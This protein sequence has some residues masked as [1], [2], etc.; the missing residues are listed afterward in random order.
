MLVRLFRSNQ[1]GVMVVLALLV[2][3][4]FLGHF[5]ATPADLSGGMPLARALA[6]LFARYPWVYGAAVTL[7][8]VAMALQVTALMNATELTVRRNHLPALL[9]PIAL[10]LVAPP[11]GVGAAF[12]AM[13]FVVWAMH[14]T[15]SMTSGGSALG[16]LFDAGLLL[17]IAAQVYVPFAFLLVVV[18]ASVSVIR[19]FQWREYLVPFIG[20]VVV[21]YLAWGILVLQHST[22]VSPLRTVIGSTIGLVRAPAG[23]GWTLALV[24]APLLLVA[25]L[26]FIEYYGRGV[27]REQN[28]RSAF[29]AFGLTLA[30]LCLLARFITDRF[31]V[32]LVAVPLAMLATFAVVGTRRAWLGEMAIGS[33]LLLA[34]WLQY[35]PA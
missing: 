7:T 9:V 23:F 8:V 12:F 24:L 32:V 30:L 3:G 26:R 11:G 19:P 4:L 25:M 35:A 21:F 15:W 10:A 20:V 17:G 14:R 18:W 28:I 31:P 16:P 29:I 34:I 2:P 5:W 22:A 33:L 27:V 6:G 1:P 13:P